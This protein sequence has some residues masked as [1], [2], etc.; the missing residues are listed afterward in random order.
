M[1]DIWRPVLT[2]LGPYVTEALIGIIS[3]LGALVTGW[4]RNR[5][6]KLAGKEMVQDVEATSEEH[7]DIK[8]SLAAN[9]MRETMGP[10][11]KPLTLNG[12]EKLAR[13]L[14]KELGKP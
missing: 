3:A 8:V 6:Q 9:R 7:T 2:A 5:A 11:I 12:A 1:E 13:E 10:H 14:R 4:L